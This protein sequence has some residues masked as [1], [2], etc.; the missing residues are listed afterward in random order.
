[1]LDVSVGANW[2]IWQVAA[3]IE[4]AAEKQRGIGLSVSLVFAGQTVAVPHETASTFYGDGNSSSSDGGGGEG[5]DSA[6]YFVLTVLGDIIPVELARA[7][8]R[9][10]QQQQQADPVAP[11]VSRADAD[12]VSASA[13]APASAP[14]SA[15]AAAEGRARIGVTILTGF[16]GTGKTTLLNHLLYEQSHMRIAVIENEFGA[17]ALDGDLIA[18]DDKM[19]AAEQVVVLGNGCM[20]CSVRGDILGAFSAIAE[21][22]QK[23]SPL[24]CVLIETTGMADPVPIVRTISQTPAIATDF[25]MNGVVSLAAA[26]GAIDMLQLDTEGRGEA[27]RQISFADRIVLSKIDLVNADTAAALW[28]QLRVMNPHARITSCVKGRLH[29]QELG[30]FHSFELDNTALH[31]YEHDRHRKSDDEHG[32]GHG[33]EG[34]HN[35]H[36]HHH[37]HHGHHD[38]HHAHHHDHHHDHHHEDGEHCDHPSHEHEH[39]HASDVGTFSIVR[40]GMEVCPIEF[41]RWTRR[42]AMPEDPETRGSL[43]R[44]KAVLASTGA[45]HKLIF[46][47]VADVMERSDGDCWAPD[48]TRSCRIV[49]IG[50]NLDRKWFEESFEALLHPIPAPLLPA[51]VATAAAIAASSN[52]SPLQTLLRQAP[53]A[54]YRVVALCSSPEAARIG[55]TCRE[56]H[57]ALYAPTAFAALRAA[58]GGANAR[59]IHPQP[60]AG[61]AARLYLHTLVP[62]TVAGAYARAAAAAKVEVVTYPGL[63]FLTR[64][65]VESA[66]MTWLELA[67]LAQPEE[68]AFV[69]DF[70]WRAA[71]LDTFFDSAAASTKSA[72]AKVEYEAQPGEWDALK[73]RAMLWPVKAADVGEEG[74]GEQKQV[75]EQ[76]R[77]GCGEAKEKER[78]P[79]AAAAL[80]QHRLVMQIVGGKSASQVYS[81]SFHSIDPCFQAHVPVPDHRNPVV[82]STEIFNKF[83]PLFSTLRSTNRLRMLCRVMPDGSGL[84]GDMCGCC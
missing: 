58:G 22:V 74:G 43:Y 45:S 17:E 41:A 8:Q 36:D 33:H 76:E 64:A 29:P 62:L 65:E 70:K 15:S 51:A 18:K 7:R 32:H 30:G 44:C 9:H 60:V 56:L 28:T 79:A 10:Q 47:A 66:G 68:S 73:F 16:L 84:L 23:G 71:T 25:V 3:A 38:Q 57:D 52:I 4:V 5:G 77:E 24:D 53:A 21:R 40:K 75:R 78:Q 26:R 67:E 37:D 6:S 20:C 69:I 61:R 31:D 35:P 50:K 1:M 82:E 59:G 46:H 11:S 34:E 2:R 49:F 42:V 63:M 39:S 54:F 13:S 48:E 81:L 19:S 72:L 55:A 27:Q 83:H 12:L 14:A 80:Q